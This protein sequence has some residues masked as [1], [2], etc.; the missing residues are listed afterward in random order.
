M[1][2]NRLQRL[3]PGRNIQNSNGQPVLN[4]SEYLT[5]RTRGTALLSY[6]PDPVRDQLAGKAE[7]EFSNRGIARTIPRALNELGYTVDIVSWDDKTFSSEKSYDLL[8]QHGGINYQDL[9]PFVKNGGKIIYFSSGSYWRYHNAAE[10]KRFANFAKRHGFRPSYD[11]LIN[12]PEEKANCEANGIIAIGNDGVRKTYSKFKNVYS[13]N[14]GCYPD[15]EKR[16]SKKKPASAKDSFLFFG[17]GGAIHKGLDL[18]IEAFADLPQ[19]LYIVAHIE[20]EVR[21]VYK[22]LLERMN[23]HYVGPVDF[24]SEKYYEVMDKCSFAVLPSC[25]EGQPGSMVEC[26]NEGLVPIVTPD[27]HLDIDKF[28]FLLPT[29]SIDKI[30]E[31]VSL[32]AK[33]PLAE[34]ARRSEMARQA[35]LNKH[36]PEKFLQEFEKLVAKIVGV[37]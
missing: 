10:K 3:L 31:A 30:R 13:L 14:L 27:V 9:R 18:T 21:G 24:R 11:R 29:A 36:S 32:A 16:A 5:S 26:L 33:L 20:E 34:V 22:E 4:Y 25:S 2:R 19:H 17:G 7:N 1:F 12:Y 23:I 15:A 28:G 8:I 6:L 37:E 35:A